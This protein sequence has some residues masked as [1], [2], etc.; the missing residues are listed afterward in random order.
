[1]ATGTK[2]Q[3][4]YHYMKN[5]DQ[6]QT[7][8]RYANDP[9]AFIRE[10]CKITHPVLGK[11]PFK[12]FLFQIALLKVY[13]TRRFSITL[14]PRQMGI[15]TL[16]AAYA[17]WL[18][19]F[20]PY[21]VISMISIKETIAKNL[22]RKIKFMYENMD[23]WLRME[24]AVDTS[25][26]WA[27]VNGSE[28]NVESATENAGRSEALSCLIMDEV[29]FQRYA[30]GI[31]AS[32]QP[33]LS[34]GGQAILLSTAFG[35]GNFFH[36]EYVNAIQ[37]LN[38]F[39]PVRLKWQMHPQRNENWYLQ[40]LLTL[41][42]KRV[43]QEIDCDFLQSGYTVFDMGKIRA[44]E[45]RLLEIGQPIYE[46]LGGSLKQ[47]LA[48]DPA[49]SYTIGGDVASGRAR[50]FSSFS[51]IDENGLEHAC[52]KGKMGVTEFGNLLMK[53]GAK[54]GYATLAPETNSLG[55]GIIGNAQMEGYPN[56]YNDVRK[57]LKT[58]E[59]AYDESTTYGWFTT[60]KSRPAIISG[61]DD[62]LNDD[63]VEL[64]NPFFVEEANTFI[65]NSNNRPVALGKEQGT[66]VQGSMYEDD[67]TAAIYSD[68]AILGAC[69]ANEV[70]KRPQTLAA[71][72]PIR[73]GR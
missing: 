49:K 30:S 37:G 3:L 1:M 72:L 57:V 50:D 25:V 9:V 19:L 55:E 51:I 44:I 54:Y 41:G 65:Y 63:K 5:G 52:F 69:I 58:D 59:Y 39:Y 70:R 7:Y 64:L 21:K 4:K 67:S 32:A 8:L 10:Q 14:K 43:A 53:W 2:Q 46:T 11:I 20:H 15:S 38:G 24:V 62:D 40:Q 18:A 45:D 26:R 16:V 68:D 27:L 28:I 36:N 48:Y 60:S 12:L 56:I 35:V 73:G 23:D 42:K 17:L 34:T 22:L 66:S 13:V 6:V 47:Y 61:M 31:W 29:A 71:N 33:T